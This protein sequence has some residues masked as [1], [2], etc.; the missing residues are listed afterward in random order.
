MRNP[1]GKGHFRAEMADIIYACERNNTPSSIT[2][3]LVHDRGRFIQLLEGPEDAVD[4]LFARIRSDSRHTRVAVLL[5][6]PCLER[7]VA[8]WSM[9]FLNAGDAPLR[10]DAASDWQDI[11]QE[12]LIARLLQARDELS[13]MRLPLAV[14]RKTPA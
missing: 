12:M 1:R 10:D 14:W 2:G 11:S 13:V 7:L 8:D 4:C 3:V 6:E 5:R 9:A